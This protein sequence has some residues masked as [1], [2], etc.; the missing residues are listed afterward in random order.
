MRKPTKSNLKIP[1]MK[2]FNTLSSELKTTQ[3]F[4]FDKELVKCG[5]K[6]IYLCPAKIIN[7]W[8]Q[9]GIYQRSQHVTSYKHDLPWDAEPKR[10][11]SLVSAANNGVTIPPIN[12]HI[13]RGK[14][15]GFCFPDARHR[16]IIAFINQHKTIAAQVEA[17]EKSTILETFM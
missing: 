4:R 10:L 5:H 8:K 1:R 12:I 7:Y 6:I 13:S 3:P 11:I 14:S 2:R 16:S 15:K 9:D 17:S